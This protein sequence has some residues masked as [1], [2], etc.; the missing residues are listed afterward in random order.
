MLRAVHLHEFFN[1]VAILPPDVLH[2]DSMSLHKVWVLPQIF[3]LCCES[4]DL[5]S[6]SLLPLSFSMID[7]YEGSES[8]MA[9]THSVGLMDVPSAFSEQIIKIQQ[10][11]DVHPVTFIAWNSAG[12]LS[13]PVFRF[14][15]S[16]CVPEFRTTSVADC[17]LVRT[18]HT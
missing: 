13:V 4:K 14:Q 1:S 8:V 3:D 9:A 12:L 2:V 18:C 16:N 15:C 5:K 10:G 17:I 7:L 6:N 11:L